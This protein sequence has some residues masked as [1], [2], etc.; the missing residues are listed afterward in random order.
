MEYDYYIN[1]NERCEFYADVREHGT[2]NTVYEIHGFDIFEDGYMRD[3]KDM[4]GLAEHMQ[5]L[6]ICNGHCVVNYYG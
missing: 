2:D 6:G 5:E 4:A 1:L 3:I